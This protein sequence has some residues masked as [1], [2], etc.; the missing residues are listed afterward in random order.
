MAHVS[1]SEH[2]AHLPHP[3][4]AA[5]PNLIAA[6]GWELDLSFGTATTEDDPAAALNGGTL[7]STPVG[8][9]A[10]Y[11]VPEEVPYQPHTPAWDEPEE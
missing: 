8:F 1:Y 7:A 3:C 6:L 5:Y 10:A 11:Q 2:S 9:T 4:A